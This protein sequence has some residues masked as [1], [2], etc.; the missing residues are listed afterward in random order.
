LDWLTHAGQAD[1][2]SLDYVP[3]PANIQDL[4]STDIA[5]ILTPA[6]AEAWT[7]SF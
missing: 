4:A 2:K 7:A 1:A 6:G 3:L 5:Q